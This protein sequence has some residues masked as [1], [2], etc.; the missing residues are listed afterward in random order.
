MV[1]VFR[2]RKIVNNIMRTVIFNILLI[3][4]VGIV[5][6]IGPAVVGPAVVAQEAEQEPEIE[7]VDHRFQFSGIEVDVKDKNLNE[8]IVVVNNTERRSEQL[9]VQGLRGPGTQQVIQLRPRETRQLNITPT[10]PPGYPIYAASSMQEFVPGNEIE[11]E[12][13]VSGAFFT[14]DYQLI[15]I[16]DQPDVPHS[17]Y[18]VFLGGMVVI[19][20][21][22]A[23]FLMNSRNTR[24][25][26]PK[27]R[28]I[29][30]GVRDSPTY[31]W[32]DDDPA[33][34]KLAIFIK[35]WIK[36]WSLMVVNVT[37][38]VWGALRF[39]GAELHGRYTLD[40][41][42]FDFDIIIPE[43]LENSMVYLMYGQFIFFIPTFFVGV[44]LARTKWIELSDVNPQNGDN[45]LYWLSP[46]RFNDMKVVTKIRKVDPDSNDRDEIIRYECPK[47]WLYDINSD[48]RRE[49]Y[50]C[51][52]YDIHENIAMVS[53]SGELKQL[54]PSKV[55][56]SQRMINY[57]FETSIWAIDQWSKLKDFFVAF[58]Q[59]EANYLKARDTAIIE[60][61]QTPD[62]DGTRERVEMRLERQN[63][64]EILEDN[65]LEKAERLQEVKPDGEELI[66]E[67]T[68]NG[69]DLTTRQGGD[70]DE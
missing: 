56:S 33:I 69:S 34:L 47:N 59:K 24:L 21:T 28:S 8:F 30:T 48:T 46:E 54:N 9:L 64:A 7:Q 51:I 65:Q 23:G 66:D 68:D 70:S 52:N 6:I 11:G 45:Y 26:I 55:R 53:W 12:A 41:Y 35:D 14:I 43:L 58:V 5:P 27:N 13:D 49:S 32:S 61:A 67:E 22:A 29:T 18:I 25:A 40:F 39:L 50:E 17:S 1:N 36:A 19:L 44:Y 2:I 62:H 4:M 63:E 37:I 38:F 60:G 57:V 42:F 16:I 20:S 10:S 15:E 31:N 3:T